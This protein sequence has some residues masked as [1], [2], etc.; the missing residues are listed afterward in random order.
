MNRLNQILATTTT[1]TA[2]LCLAGETGETEEFPVSYWSGPPRDLNNLKTWQSVQDCNFTFAGP[3]FW[4]STD[5]GQGKADNLRMLDLCAQVGLKALV[6]DRRIHR[7]MTEDDGWE[8]KVA[9]VVADYGSHPGLF[10]YF[11]MDEP[12]DVHFAALGQI[13]A[14]CAKRDPKHLVYVNLF[15]NFPVKPDGQWHEY[16]I[17]VATHPKWRGRVIRAI[18]LDP[19]TGGAALCSTIIAVCLAA[20]SPSLFAGETPQQATSSQKVALEGAFGKA[21][22]DT[23][24]PA[25]VALFLRQPD[26]TLSAKS[27]LSVHPSEFPAWAVGG[28]KAISRRSSSA[29]RLCFSTRVR[30]HRPPPRRSSVS[31]RRET[32][33]FPSGGCRPKRCS[34]SF[35]RS[36]RAL[37][38]PRSSP[39]I[40]RR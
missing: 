5:T 20:I 29:N 3:S 11:L 12:S 30:T 28:G 15:L 23:S 8:E 38:G 24:A 14:E 27:L 2:L 13:R 10:G 34:L 4:W 18:R 22:V 36:T 17:P 19:T 7:Q 6:L 33:S 16:T 35:A 39:R 21:E 32:G 1:L 25:L 26:G 37:L 9:Q 40:A 31:T